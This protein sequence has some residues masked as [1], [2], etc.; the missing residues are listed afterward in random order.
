MKLKF[1]ANITLMLREQDVNL[2]LKAVEQFSPETQDEARN[3]E[4]LLDLLQYLATES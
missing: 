4:Y 2:L 3:R 1:E